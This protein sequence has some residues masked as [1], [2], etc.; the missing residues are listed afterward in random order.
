ML[1]FAEPAESVAEGG[2]GSS[3]SLSFRS[4]VVSSAKNGV[5]A[6]VMAWISRSLLAAKA[7][8]SSSELKVACTTGAVVVGFGVP[9]SSMLWD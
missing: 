2:G 9:I 5:L 4:N 3:L 8:L 7:S 6:S 1:V